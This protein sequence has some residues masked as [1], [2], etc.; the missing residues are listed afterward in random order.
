MQSVLFSFI[1]KIF[2]CLLG[3][4]LV[5]LAGFIYKKYH[6]YLNYTW[7]VKLAQGAIAAIKAYFAANPDAAK[8]AQAVFAMF[9]DE[10]TQVLP[11]SDA[12]IMYLFEDVETALAELLGIDATAFASLKSTVLL[13]YKGKKIKLF[14]GTKHLFA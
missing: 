2:V 10:L 4:G 9:K 8:T 5:A 3:T 1:V 6:G 12:E 11:L 7:G 14:G 13:Q